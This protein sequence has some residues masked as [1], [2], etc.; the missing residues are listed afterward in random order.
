MLAWFARSG[1]RLLTLNWRGNAEGVVVV[2]YAGHS[3]GCVLAMGATMRGLSISIGFG[4]MLAAIVA[5]AAGGP[6]SAAEK[7]AGAGL[8]VAIFSGSKEYDSNESLEK[9]K[10]VLEE[11]LGAQCSINIVEEKGTTLT[12]SEQLESADV[13]VIFTRRVALSAE[14]L[15]KVKKFVQ[16]G[17]G[18]VGI[19]TASHAFQTWLEFD[20]EIL[21]GSYNNHYGKEAPAEVLVEEKGK[22]HPVMKGVKG[23]A[24]NGK[25]YKNPKL[26]EDATLLL[27]IKAKEYD[28]P[29][30]W[31]R[32][33]KTGERGRVFYTSLGV[34]KDFDDP[35]FQKLVVNAVGWTGGR[36]VA[37]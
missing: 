6:A 13:A 32:D 17:G 31:V 30:A 12:G 36:D 4:A 34:Q 23:F 9:L 19:R 33:A 18:I 8:K 25:G 5:M 14:E 29:A 28:E 15:A 22:E 1:G 35:E 20:H 11:K 24:T 37:K 26:A 7:P 27:R 16:R 21:G 2:G 3:R 10:K